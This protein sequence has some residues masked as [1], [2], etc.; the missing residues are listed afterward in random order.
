MRVQKIGLLAYGSLRWRPEGLLEVLEL[1]GA[2]DVET[3]FAIE[4]A[5]TSMWRDG[6]PTLVPV[7]SGGSRVAAAVIP[8]REGISVSDAQTRVWRRELLRTSG[9]YD[10]VSNAGSPNKV[11]VEPIEQRI[12]E[13]EVVLSVSIG[14]NIDDLN[15]EVL[16]DLAIASSRAPAG[17]RREDG[18]T[19]LIEAKKQK[20]ETPLLRAYE[21]AILR[22][23]AVASLDEAWTAARSSSVDAAF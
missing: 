10:R 17:A 11:Y 19:Y 6:C 7:E 3:P 9:T 21:E 18:I 20:I 2:V 5:R 16:A 1:P 23:M 14:S 15:A 8:F 4:F 12:A 13:F 22:R